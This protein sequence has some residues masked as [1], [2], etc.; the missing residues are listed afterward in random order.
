MTKPGSIT[1]QIFSFQATNDRNVTVH[2][3]GFPNRS[4]EFIW[5]PSPA[6]ISSWSVYALE[7]GPGAFPKAPR[8][9][10]ALGPSHDRWGAW[11]LTSSTPCLPA[12]T[13]Q[14][15]L[16]TAAW[17]AQA[18]HTG[19]LCCKLFLCFLPR[20]QFLTGACFPFVSGSASFSCLVS[21]RV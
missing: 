15:V 18:A 13:L 14:K 3:K 20:F 16:A 11:A 5:E 6:V 8:K 7:D 4:T 19:G 10:S 9:P 2:D 17:C 1:P 21:S 12:R